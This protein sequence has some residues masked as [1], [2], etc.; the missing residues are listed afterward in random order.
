[1]NYYEAG[2]GERPLTHYLPYLMLNGPLF[3]NLKHLSVHFGPSFSGDSAVNTCHKML[4]LFPELVSRGSPG[5]ETKPIANLT[6]RISG[7]FWDENIIE[8]LIQQ[9]PHLFHSVRELRLELA[10]MS[11]N[12]MRLLAPLESLQTL[13]VDIR[14]FRSKNESIA[15]YQG[16]KRLRTLRLT[17]NAL[18]TEVGCILSRLDP[19]L[20]IR[21]LTLNIDDSSS[22]GAIPF[23]DTSL[24][25][26][27]EVLELA[28]PDIRMKHAADILHNRIESFKHLQELKLI[29]FSSIAGDDQEWKNALQHL[30]QLH[31]LSLAEDA[32]EF[33]VLDPAPTLGLI[34][35]ALECCP[36][37]Y[38]IAGIFDLSEEHI[39]RQAISKKH[40]RVQIIDL[41]NSYF[42]WFVGCPGLPDNLGH[43]ED[44]ALRAG[45]YLSSFTNH[46]CRIQI[47]GFEINYSFTRPEE[48]KKWRS[49]AL[50]VFREKIEATNNRKFYVP[51]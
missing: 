25:E 21:Q 34:Q 44:W 51:L 49:N 20:D 7:S 15:R 33:R 43:P 14:E 40:L 3:P 41:R 35:L 50:H 9:Y 17:P 29:S 6:L 11:D 16:F 28:V 37:L 31:T 48:I 38:R 46:P 4:R 39:P 19:G 8:S 26:G 13:E 22:W 47:T 27:L 10:F 42:R 23:P 12:F 45:T 36:L 2:I 18:L 30:P 24:L 5:Q 32:N 1:V